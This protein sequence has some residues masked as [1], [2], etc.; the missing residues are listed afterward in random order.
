MTSYFALRYYSA[1]LVLLVGLATFAG[2]LGWG[3]ALLGLVRWRLPTPWNEVTATLLGLQIL[4]SMVQ[5]LG[6]AR[7]AGPPVLISLWV[8]LV[9][10]GGYAAV[11]SRS[12]KLRTSDPLPSAVWPLVLV[13]IVA[14]LARLLIATAPSTKNDEIYYHML[15]PSRIATDGAM[16]FY[17]SPWV[18]A[19]WPQ[20]TFQIAM[21]PLHSIRCP[22]ASNVVSVAFGLQLLWFIRRLARETEQP[23]VW[24]YFWLGILSVGLYPV[25][26][27]VTAGSHALGDLAMTAAVVA[28]CQRDRLIKSAGPVAYGG[29]VS[30]MC[31]AAGSTKISLLPLSVA[32]LVVVGFALFRR[33]STEQRKSAA[34]VMACPW[35]LF[36]GPLLAWTWVQSGSPLG[37]ILSGVLGHSVYD[38]EQ[39]RKIFQES[40]DINRPS[41]ASIVETTLLNYSPLLWL[42][43]VGGLIRT[44]L[45]RADKWIGGGLL[46]LQLLV[47]YILLPYDVRFL[48]GLHYGLLT[49]F[50]LAPPARIVEWVAARNIRAFVACG[51]LLPWLAVQLYYAAQFFPIVLRQQSK[52]A[53]CRKYIAFFDD[54][55]RLDRILP[56]D[57]I[58]LMTGFRLGA[59]YAPRPIYLTIS[60]LPPNREVY[61]FANSR[62]AIGTNDIAPGYGTGPVVYENAHAIAETFRTPGRPSIEMPLHVVR[63]IRK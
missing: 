51:L 44:Q 12:R 57:S 11:R 29:M 25:V 47:I 39:I 5:W 9:V 3:S 1:P 8:A 41:F 38:P 58:L 54:F 30:T 13:C 15:T 53:F 23:A 16:L 10:T 56:P 43:I 22:D 60:D 37:P 6:M 50:I 14:W 46:L 48:G 35:V 24:T 17:Q 45:P 49:W 62:E 26:W 59:I 40:R 18:S 21:A 61:M 20:M 31:W 4:S 28:F 36:A 42:G 7:L 32:L 19:I 27:L 33:L 63:V 55:R 52:N 34:F 2:M